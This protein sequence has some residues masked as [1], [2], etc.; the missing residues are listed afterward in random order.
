MTTFL[1]SSISRMHV[2]VLEL[3]LTVAMPFE[4]ETDGGDV[5]GYE[6]STEKQTFLVGKAISINRIVT[7]LRIIR[8][9]VLRF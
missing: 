3:T 4:V 6:R 2:H 9:D 5:I 1:A 7:L 8:I